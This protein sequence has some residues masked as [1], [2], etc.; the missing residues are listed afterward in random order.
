MIDVCNKC[1]R[2]WCVCPLE[3]S[4]W[5]SSSTENEIDALRKDVAAYRAEIAKS[6]AENEKL[7]SQLTYARKRLKEFIDCDVS[8]CG[9]FSR[10][11]YDHGFEQYCRKCSQAIWDAADE[12]E[13]T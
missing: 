13:A 2:Y 5:T 7:R 8:R 10:G 12:L 9:D 3:W 4:S 1:L 11:D 6:D